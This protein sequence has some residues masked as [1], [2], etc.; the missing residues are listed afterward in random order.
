[1]VLTGKEEEKNIYKDR[2][3]MKKEDNHYDHMMIKMS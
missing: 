2:K 1:M 3:K